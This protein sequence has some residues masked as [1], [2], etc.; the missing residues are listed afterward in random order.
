[1][2][3][4]F[5]HLLTPRVF[6]DTSKSEKYASDQTGFDPSDSLHSI[7]DYR[8]RKIASKRIPSRVA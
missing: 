8:L 5:Q 6:P 2:F 3:E 4:R 1:M 7:R